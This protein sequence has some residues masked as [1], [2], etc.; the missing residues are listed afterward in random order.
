MKDICKALND[1]ISLSGHGLFSGILA[2]LKL[3]PA[4]S[5]GIFFQRTDLP[6]APII[7]ATLKYVDIS[8]IRHTVLNKDG[9]VVETPEHILSA[10]YG[11]NIDNVKIELDGP[12]VPIFDGSATIFVEALKKVATIDFQKDFYTISAPIALQEEKSLMIA[13]P[14]DRL[15]ISCLLDY[16]GVACLQNQLFSLDI[17]D[18][19]YMQSLAKARTFATKEALLT[20]KQAG[21]FKKLYRG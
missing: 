21:F 14:S 8:A 20:L 11:L 6:T 15:T 3:K 17:T 4:T 2:N 12:E 9:V 10:L 7:E 16:K 1:N 13:L 18:E 19:S 5:P